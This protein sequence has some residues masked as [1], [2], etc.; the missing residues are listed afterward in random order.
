MTGAMH[1]YRIFGGILA[2]EL[3]L[4]DLAEAND[5]DP[6]WRF[7]RGHPAGG[8]SRSD[9]RS[10]SGDLLGSEPVMDGVE[11]RL[12]RTRDGYRLD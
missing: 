12:Y 7:E 6:D 1:R 11:V 5:G 2:S 10:P 8:V 3:S 9:D 4:P